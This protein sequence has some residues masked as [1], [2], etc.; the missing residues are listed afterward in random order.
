[1]A[2]E[3]EGAGPKGGAALEPSTPLSLADAATLAG[4]E[5]GD[6]ERACAEGTLIF[7]TRRVRKK[8]VRVVRLMDLGELFPEVIGAPM[9]PGPATPEAEPTAGK[10]TADRHPTPIAPS[11]DPVAVPSRAE[12]GGDLAEAVRASGAS[13]D[14]LIT[15]CQ[16]LESRLD[17]AE[18]E[19]QASTAS[20]LMA[21]RRV[22]DLELRQKPSPWG[23]VGVG[24]LLGVAGVATFAALR[25]PGLVEAAAAERLDAFE[26]TLAEELGEVRTR[27]SAELEGEREVRV[28]L[29]EQL[30]AERSALEATQGLVR[31]VAAQG[32]AAAAAE[33]DR[34]AETLTELE[35]RL[36]LARS[37]ARRDGDRLEAAL[38]AAERDR[39]RFAERLASSERASDA[40]RSSLAEERRS[41]EAARAAYQAELDS[42]LERLEMSSRTDSRRRAAELEVLRAAVDAQVASRNSATERR[43]AE[44]GAAAPVE[45]SANVNRTEPGESWPV[46]LWRA[47]S[48]SRSS[49]G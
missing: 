6:L 7:E 43:P 4:V 33:R 49:D 15:L 5:V 35:S 44:S 27:L 3:R 29:T 18:R 39:S 46:R 9:G 48:G 26:A 23:R 8:E 45:A 2:R 14:A 1:M 21:Q 34:F 28:A 31:E 42:L 24:M 40:A 37:D 22:L 11:T 41:N 17:L 32:A 20:L 10:G 19:R 30:D 13:R 38:D 16:D 12:T 25:A 36:E 47:L